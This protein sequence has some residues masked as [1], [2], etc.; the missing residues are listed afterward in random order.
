MHW[1]LVRD[2]VQQNK[3][4]LISRHQL[5]DMVMRIGRKINSETVRKMLNWGQ[6]EFRQKLRQKTIEFGS[7]A[8]ELSE[9]YTSKS[10]VMCGRIHWKLDESKTFTC[11]YCYFSIDRD[12]N[13]AHEHWESCI[14]PLMI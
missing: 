6:F 4:I 10:C 7:V 12:F 13:S 8:H 5:F 14:I 2:I 9:H 11:R 3:H 1:K